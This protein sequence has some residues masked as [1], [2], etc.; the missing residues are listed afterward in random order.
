[1]SDV[2]ERR[3]KPLAPFLWDP[4]VAQKKASS[5][6]RARPPVDHS[7]PPPT[8]SL[9]VF[10]DDV[11][12]AP[13]R[14]RQGTYGRSVGSKGNLLLSTLGECVRT[15][16]NDTPPITNPSLPSSHHPTDSALF[17]FPISLF[18]TWLLWGFCFRSSDSRSS[19]GQSRFEFERRSR[20]KSKQRCSTFSTTTT[21]I[22]P[23][24]LFTLFPFFFSV[25]VHP[26]TKSSSAKKKV[27][28]FTPTAASR[29]FLR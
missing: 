8:F 5:L 17:L 21:G 13:E 14:R 10:W 24:T 2:P 18:W 20:S 11:I 3:P 6:L 15:I 9:R 27:A 1:M 4:R 22:P 25:H 23:T 16:W 26:A 7:P 12:L 29:P 19:N 28:S